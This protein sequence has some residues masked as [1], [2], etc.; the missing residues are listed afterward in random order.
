M[1]RHELT[2][3]LHDGLREFYAKND[4]GVTEELDFALVHLAEFL[5]DLLRETT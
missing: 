2:S 5:A 4:L 1:D 3:R